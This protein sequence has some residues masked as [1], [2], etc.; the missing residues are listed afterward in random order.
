MK[1]LLRKEWHTIYW[2]REFLDTAPN[3]DYLI[4]DYSPPRNIDQNSLLHAYLTYVAKETGNEMYALKELM[5]KKFASKKKM[6]KIG[7]KKQY[8]LVIEQTSKMNK[9]RFAEFLTDVEWFF[10]PFGYPIPPRDNLEFQALINSY[11]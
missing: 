7:W 6:V 8:A 1:K 11:S 3:G 5:K 4:Q 9:K 2:L 10:A